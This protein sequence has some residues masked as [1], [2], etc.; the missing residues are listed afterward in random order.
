[1]ARKWRGDSWPFRLRLGSGFRAVLAEEPLPDDVRRRPVNRRRGG[2]VNSQRHSRVGMA[3]TDLGRLHVDPPDHEGGGVHLASV[4]EPGP[5]TTGFL[6]GREPHPPAPV[7]VAQRPAI[8]VGENQGVALVRREPSLL[9]VSG[10]SMVTMALGMNMARLPAR[11]FGGP[12]TLR[13]PIPRTMVS[14]TESVPPLPCRR[15]R[16][17]R[18][19]IMRLTQPRLRLPQRR[20]PMKPKRY[21]VAARTSSLGE[22]L[23]RCAPLPSRRRTTTSERL[24]RTASRRPPGVGRTR[25]RRTP[26][27]GQRRRAGS[28]GNRE[29]QGL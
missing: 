23:A 10:E 22:A 5:L 6:G 9:E 27:T 8:L 21:G 15:S 29:R 12:K 11:D 2:G 4:V 24:R 7:R 28:S 26:P 25:R 1:M 18:I 16:S 20:R 19:P 17:W 13:L 14:T 3:E